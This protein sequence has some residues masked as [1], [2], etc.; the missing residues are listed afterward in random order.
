MS[1]IAAQIL[2]SRRGSSGMYVCLWK[3]TRT[4]SGR[5]GPR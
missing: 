2:V 1:N 5:N 3:F 4:P